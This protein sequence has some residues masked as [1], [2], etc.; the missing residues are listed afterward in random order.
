MINCFW[1]YACQYYLDFVLIIRLIITKIFDDVNF[2]DD[3]TLRLIFL[4]LLSYN[5]NVT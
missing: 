1:L 2:L 5:H 4:L 3:I